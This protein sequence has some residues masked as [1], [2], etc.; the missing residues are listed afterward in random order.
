VKTKKKE[1]KKE[2]KEKKPFLKFFEEE[3]KFFWRRK[4]ST[5][6]QFLQKRT[7]KNITL[8]LHNTHRR[9]KQSVSIMNIFFWTRL[10]Y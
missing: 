2:K 1:Q 6:K 5:R 8:S 7:V 10:F 3:T 4:K 9:I